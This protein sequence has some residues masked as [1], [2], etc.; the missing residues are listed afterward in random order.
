MSMEMQSLDYN[1]LWKSRETSHY[2]QW[3]DK[4]A[5]CTL[6]NCNMVVST[7]IARVESVKSWGC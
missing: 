7:I 4:L 1:I 3:Q 5:Y 6:N 2:G